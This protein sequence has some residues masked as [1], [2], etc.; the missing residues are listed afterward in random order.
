MSVFGIAPA[1]ANAIARLTGVRIKD[2]PMS[3]ENVLEQLNQ[4]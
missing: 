3:A 2:L 4:S 1:V